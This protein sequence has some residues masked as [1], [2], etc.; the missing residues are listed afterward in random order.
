MR[1]DD[2]ADLDALDRHI[3][4]LYQLDTRVS[5]EALGARVGLSAAAVQRRL[6]RLRE[7]GVIVVET[8]LLDPRSLGLDVTALVHV[9]LVDES[10]RAGHAFRDR[11]LAH[12]Q[13]QQCYG[14]TGDA[15]YVLVVVVPSMAAYEAFCD[16]CL[17]HDAN[18][19]SYHTQI[20]LDAA[21][22]WGG[23]AIPGA[24]NGE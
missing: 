7:E 3:L 13:V 4:S 15:D 23:L 10:A 8:A 19:R 21:R 22:R 6:K 14:V 20:V 2:V 16:A 5:S 24:K 12:P 18:V 9:D 1:Q 11:M 17:M